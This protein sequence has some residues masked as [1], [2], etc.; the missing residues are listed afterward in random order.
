MEVKD[1]PPRPV[2]LASLLLRGRLKPVSSMGIRRAAQI[3]PNE[4]SSADT[5]N[6]RARIAPSQSSSNPQF[7]TVVSAASRAV[8][9]SKGSTRNPMRRRTGHQ[10]VHISLLLVSLETRYFNGLAVEVPE[11]LLPLKDTVIKFSSAD[12]LTWPSFT[13]ILFDHLRPL[14]PSIDP[15]NRDLWGLSY[16]SSFSGKKIVTV[17]NTDKYATPSSMLASGHFGNNQAGQPKVLVVLTSTDVIDK[18]EPVT[19]LKPDEYAT[20][21]KE[22]KKRKLKQEDTSP[23]AGHKKRI[24]KER[25]INEEDS[26]EMTDQIKQETP[27]RMKQEGL[28]L[29]PSCQSPTDDEIEDVFDEIVVCEDV[30][31]LSGVEDPLHNL[32]FRSISCKRGHEGVVGDADEVEEEGGEEGLD[33]EFVRDQINTCRV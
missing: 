12:L 11:T 20:P 26:T 24:K 25:Q 4:I 7:M 29:S 13:A 19:P 3:L 2:S 23:A 17:P 22:E 33:L 32:A 5:V 9:N 16:A 28:A 8:Q 6:T 21:V 18:Q 15:T 10:W 27:V 30:I 1:S 14:P 31:D